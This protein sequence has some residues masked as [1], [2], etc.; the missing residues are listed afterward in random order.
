MASAIDTSKPIAGSPTTQSVRDQ[1]TTAAS[2]ITSLQANGIEDL[3]T[4]EVDQL[5]NI[6]T[7]TISA[8]QWIYLGA[9][10]QAL[11]TTDSITHVNFTATGFVYSSVTDSITAGS[12]QTQAGATALTTQ[13]NRVT[14]SGTN[15]DGVKLPTGVNCGRVLV[16]NA[17]AAQTIQIWPAT[18]DSIDGGSVDAVDSNTL[19]AGAEREYV[20]VGV[21]NWNT[22]TPTGGAGDLVSTNNLSDVAN[23]GTS[24]TNLGVAI[25]SDVQAFGAILDD[26]N[27]LGADASDGQFIVA[28]GAGAFA[29]ESTT[30]ARTS[31]GVGTGD[32]PQFTGIELGHASDTTVTRSAAGVLAV[33][34][35]AQAAKTGVNATKQVIAIAASDE[36]TALTTGAA[37]VTFHMPYAFTLTDVKAGVTTAPTGATLTV[38]INEAGSTILS[39]KITIDI[40]EKTSGTAAT[41]PVISDASLA[42]DALMTI[43]IDQVGSTV[44]G[45]GLKVYLIG[46][47]T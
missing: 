33:E 8:A 14:V 27:T 30:T 42:E 21:T 7:T 11:A 32:S 31:L 24:R 5:E 19:A 41:P 46:Y 13:V 15:G 29:Y 35:V 40:S 3:T 43:D 20:M 34:G 25:G 26:F 18:S 38:D 1:F 36:A 44:A 28:T 45:A 4:A 39:T 2:E 23:A 12:T 6:G 17:D 37:K 47:I 22:V 9:S 10:D 16:I